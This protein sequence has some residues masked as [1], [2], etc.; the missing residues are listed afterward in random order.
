MASALLRLIAVTTDFES[1]ES[2]IR[3]VRSSLRVLRDDQGT[4]VVASALKAAAEALSGIRRY[5]NRSDGDPGQM[6]PII[7]FIDELTS[8]LLPL[9]ARRQVAR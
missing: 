3:R 6:L 2:S 9:V 8:M 7:E 1:V 4:L 5:L